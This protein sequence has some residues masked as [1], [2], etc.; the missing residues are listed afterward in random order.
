MAKG[1]P[2]ELAS[3]TA[4]SDYF[5]SLQLQQKCILNLDLSSYTTA[6][7][8]QSYVSCFCVQLFMIPWTAEWQAHLIF[9]SFSKLTFFALVTLSKHLI[10]YRPLR[11]SSSIFPSIRHFSKEP[12]LFMRQAYIHNDN[13]VKKHQCGKYHTEIKA[14]LYLVLGHH[15]LVSLN[16]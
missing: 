15:K 16:I 7:L 3:F 14:K 10:L 4:I 1:T 9:P 5:I 8:K 2:T 6:K 11:L 12:S 13:V